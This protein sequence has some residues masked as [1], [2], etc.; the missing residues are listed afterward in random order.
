MDKPEKGM[1]GQIIH[2]GAL[3]TFG[4][5]TIE[6]EFCDSDTESPFTRAE[7]LADHEIVLNS[8]REA[9]RHYLGTLR[10]DDLQSQQA[11]RYTKTPPLAI[12]G[13]SPDE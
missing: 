5:S 8:S 9:M 1:P 4:E 10:A 3:F 11:E 12:L 13:G 2:E 6:V 7:I